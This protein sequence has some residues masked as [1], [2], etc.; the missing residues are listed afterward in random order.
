MWVES[1]GTSVIMGKLRGGKISKL[2][3][4]YIHQWW[5]MTIAALIEFS[6]S[7]IR[8][9][10]IEPLWRWV[11]EYIMIIHFITYGFLVFVL[12]NNIKSKGF[13]LILL[14]I[15]LN[16]IVIMAN[17][18]RMPV[19]ISGIDPILFREK[20]DFLKAGKDLVHAVMD[21]TTSLKFL[22]DIIHLK[23]PY[24]MPKTLS[25]GDIFMM[26]GVFLF[27]QNQMLRDKG[28]RIKEIG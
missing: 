18:G 27:V 2:T 19:D 14:G 22:G 4:I 23:K 5:Y 17:G 10:E 26:L 7:W 1:L 16:F 6:A 11:D 25:I 20:I 12:I 28:N 15:M 21:E 13:P 3:D 24:P 9:K 8:M